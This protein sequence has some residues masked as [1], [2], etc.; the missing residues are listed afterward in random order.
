M[1]GEF[2][3]LIGVTSIE[4]KLILITDSSKDFERLNG[5]KIQNWF[6]GI[7]QVKPLFPSAHYQSFVSS[8]RNL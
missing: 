2:Y 5:I 3:L 7:K 8:F 4:N 1:H 6:K